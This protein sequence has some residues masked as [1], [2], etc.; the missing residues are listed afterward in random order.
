MFIFS[1]AWDEFPIALTHDQHAVPLHAAH[2][3]GRLHRRPHVAWGPFFAGS[4]IATDPGRQSSSSSPSAGPQRRLPRGAALNS[5]SG[6]AGETSSL[7]PPRV[8]PGPCATV[9]W[10]LRTLG[11]V[12][13]FYPTGQ[14][15][16]IGALPGGCR[17]VGPGEPPERSAVARPVGG[18]RFIGLG[19]GTYSIGGARPRGRATGRGTDDGRRP[20]GRAPGA[21]LCHLVPGRQSRRRAGLVEGPQV[22]GRAD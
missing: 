21:R 9:G 7:P 10:A 1:A 5:E 4:V 11:S 19:P 16:E 12:R 22:H 13:A 2:R 14:E 18:M 20:P 8:P 15:I 17:Q 3:P 6:P